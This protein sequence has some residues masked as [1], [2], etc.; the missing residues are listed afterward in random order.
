MTVRLFQDYWWD[1]V[2]PYTKQVQNAVSKKQALFPGRSVS[3]CCI[4][5]LIQKCINVPVLSA[6]IPTLPCY[7]ELY[8][9]FSAL[10]EFNWLNS[11]K[12]FSSW[13]TLSHF[14][15][16]LLLFLIDAEILSPRRCIFSVFFFFFFQNVLILVWEKNNKWLFLTVHSNK[17]FNKLCNK[18][19]KKMLSPK[20]LSS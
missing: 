9:S 7:A 4:N 2:K 14:A 13:F 20:L 18:D 6:L 8:S 15:F 16:I 5:D 19:F 17:M 12:H 1:G 3:Y 11:F 10:S